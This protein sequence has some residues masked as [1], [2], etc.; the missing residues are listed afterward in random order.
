[1]YYSQDIAT[2]LANMTK[3]YFYKPTSALI[4]AIVPAKY[5]KWHNKEKQYLVT[6]NSNA[7]SSPPPHMRKLRADTMADLQ[8]TTK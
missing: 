8:T 6:Q 4:A 2:V 3:S 5:C 1:M 7:G